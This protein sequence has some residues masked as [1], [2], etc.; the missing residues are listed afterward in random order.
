M[1]VYAEQLIASIL[2][3]YGLHTNHHQDVDASGNNVDRMRTVVLLHAESATEQTM[4]WVPAIDTQCDRIATRLKRKTRAAL[5]EP[6]SRCNL[7]QTRMN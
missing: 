2:F 7:S 5:L 1:V 3:Q 4:P 6:S